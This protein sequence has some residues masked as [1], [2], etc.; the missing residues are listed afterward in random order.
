MTRPVLPLRRVRL[1]DLAAQGSDFDRVALAAPDIDAFCSSTAWV[2]S[3]HQAFH[4][5]QEPWI[6]HDGQSWLVL[7]HALSPDIGRY[8]APM[9]AMWGLASPLISAAPGAFAFRCAEAL[10]QVEDTWDALWLCGLKPRSEAFNTLAFC[11]GQHYRMFM[12]PT[13]RR[14]VASLEGGFEGYLSRRRRTFRKSLRQAT[15]RA[16]AAGISWEWHDV[17]ADDV[18]RGAC[19]RRALAVD[20]KSWK[21]L[22]LQGLSVGGMARFYDLMTARL[23]EQGQLRVVIGRIDDEDVAM[24]FGA[25]FGDTF[26][27]LQ[28]SFDDR[29]RELSLGNLV[30]AQ[31]IERLAAEGCAAYDLGTEMAYKERWSEPGLETVALVVRR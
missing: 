26:R 22:S 2:V 18:E 28:M 1:E 17:F 4:P 9:E 10:R 23:A 19:Y 11:L 16:E 30:Q 5:E 21:G 6:W 3:A 27:G 13:T 29:L 7:A 31:L 8:L 15:R 14:H 25:A 12:G 20:D 24:G